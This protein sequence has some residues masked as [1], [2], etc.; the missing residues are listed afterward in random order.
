MELHTGRHHTAASCRV[1]L[2]TSNLG[3]LG[4][5]FDVT[6]NTLG[7]QTER[8]LGYGQCGVP[9]LP[10]IYQNALPTEQ[11]GDNRV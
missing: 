10:V 8:R 5:L 7:W 2:L 6:S 9:C 1:G 4:L 11:E 3:L